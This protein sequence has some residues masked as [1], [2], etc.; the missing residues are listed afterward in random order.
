MER[1]RPSLARYQ[2]TA[3]ATATSPANQIPHINHTA[4]QPEMPGYMSK[5]AG[6]TKPGIPSHGPMWT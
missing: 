6:I 5:G 2:Q 1:G 4:D 3:S